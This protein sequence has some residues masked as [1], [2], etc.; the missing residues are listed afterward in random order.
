MATAK[1]QAAMDH[2]NHLARNDAGWTRKR[3]T[4]TFVQ[5][6][7]AVRSKTDMSQKEFAEALGFTAQYLCDLEHG[8]RCGSVEFVNRLCDW[9]EHGPKARKA[10]HLAAARAHGWEV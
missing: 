2:F 10:W 7:V 4:M 6:L 9:L 5:L 1:E 3:A 8:R